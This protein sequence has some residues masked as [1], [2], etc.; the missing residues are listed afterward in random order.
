MS[1]KGN[2]ISL[3]TRRFGLS[4]RR[5]KALREKVVDHLDATGW[6]T[7]GAQGRYAAAAHRGQFL[8][9]FENRDTYYCWKRSAIV[10]VER[11][12]SACAHLSVM[13]LAMKKIKK[14]TVANDHGREVNSFRS[15]YKV[16]PASE[17]M[18]RVI[19]DEKLPLDLRSHMAAV[20][21]PFMHHKLAAITPDDIDPPEK[22]S[23]DLSKHTNEELEQLRRILAKSDTQR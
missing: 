3:R 6:S 5:A 12:N 1:K 20:A 18:L 8:S 21:L 10:V 11:V 7:A 23:L 14:K 4:E 16:Q 17:Y 15:R 9:I 19:N 2:L 22:T 13:E